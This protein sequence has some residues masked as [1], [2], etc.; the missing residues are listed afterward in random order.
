MAG[1]RR[2]RAALGKAGTFLQQKWYMDHLWAKL[3]SGTMYIGACIAEFCD[4]R[5]FDGA[6]SGI[7]HFTER[8]GEVLRQEHSGY[9][10]NYLFIIIVAL[11]VLA[12]AIGYIE[13]SFATSPVYW[14]KLLQSH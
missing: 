10:Q 13:P 2:L 5:V 14:S 6:V 12:I 1:E 9:V 8:M 3:L 11:V 7:A 4:N